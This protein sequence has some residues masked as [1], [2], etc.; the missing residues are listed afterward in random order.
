MER[1]K[2]HWFFTLLGLVASIIAIFG[3]V[4]GIDSIRSAGGQEGGSVT[5]SPTTAPTDPV[6]SETPMDQV[7]ETPT[8]GA[9]ETPTEPVASDTPTETATSETPK[10]PEPLK[11][12]SIVIEFDDVPANIGPGKY[13]VRKGGKAGV[14]FWWTTFTNQGRL[15]GRNCTVVVQIR[16]ATTKT[17]ISDGDF[18]TAT[19]S[20]EGGWVSFRVP[21]GTFELTVKVEAPGGS[22]RTAR[23]TFA[24][25]GGA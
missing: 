5:S 9:G 3:F 19:C 17:L 21:E 12:E 20:Y 13:Q 23:S 8:E 2:D 1:L 10:P 25:Y 4:F 6:T 24:V 7:S 22:A 16:N 15:D 14:T 11:I 18:R